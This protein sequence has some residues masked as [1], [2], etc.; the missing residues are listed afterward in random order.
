MEKVIVLDDVAYAKTA[1]GTASNVNDAEDLVNGAIGIYNIKGELITGEAQLNDC[2][3]FTIAYNKAGNVILSKTYTR[4]GIFRFLNE[5]YAA[6]T[7]HKIAIGGTTAQTGLAIADD[8]E[9]HVGIRVA[10]NT[11]SSR[12]ATAVVNATVYKKASMTKA[13][14]ITKLVE[15]LNNSTTLPLTAVDVSTT[16]NAGVTVE[17]K[18]R[19]QSIYVSLSG[20]IEGGNIVKDGTGPSVLPTLGVGVGVDV[21]Q[22]ENE[23]NVF[24]GDGGSTYRADDFYSQPNNANA[25]GEYGTIMFQE[26]LPSPY[27]GETNVKPLVSIYFPNTAG[28]EDTLIGVFKLLI[29]EAYTGAT[30]AEPADDNDP[31]ADL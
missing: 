31:V 16:G 29:G 14:V 11:F 6:P 15:K 18:K 30:N 22:R 10:D 21:L 24:L 19:G 27:I 3:E 25:S 9:G 28:I 12:F 23:S 2:K 8:A 5:D 17:S 13:Q 1:T 20:L 4:R 26:D 7:L